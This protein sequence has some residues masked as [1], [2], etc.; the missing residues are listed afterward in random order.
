MFHRTP[1]DRERQALDAAGE[2]FG[3]LVVKRDCA[4]AFSGMPRCVF[5]EAIR[6]TVM[7]YRATLAARELVDSE[8]GPDE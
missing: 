5:E 4:A 2:A 1:S 7:A 6:E 8:D 3:M